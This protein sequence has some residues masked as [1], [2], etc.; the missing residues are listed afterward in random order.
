[1]LANCCAWNYTPVRIHGLV[2]IKLYSPKIMV[3]TTVWRN[4]YNWQQ[5][6][7]EVD[8]LHNNDFSGFPHIW[9]RPLFASWI[10]PTWRRDFM[11]I[12]VTS[13]H[14]Y[15]AS[16][17]EGIGCPSWS[18][19]LDGRATEITNDTIFDGGV[20]QTAFPTAPRPLWTFHAAL[21]T[22]HWVGVE[23]RGT[24]LQGGPKSNEYSIYRIKICH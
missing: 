2:Y 16:I 24:H 11:L 5:R 8:R 19:T 10:P 7:K 22:H 14:V 17:P 18:I 6:Q 20:R 15:V 3:A 1:M 13:P 4:I 23:L 21:T 12:D 9:T